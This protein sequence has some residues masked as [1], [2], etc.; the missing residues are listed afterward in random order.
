MFSLTGS[1]EIKKSPSEVYAFLVDLQNIPKWEGEVLEVKVSTPGP[2]RVGTEFTEK[3]K[4]SMKTVEARC[5]MTGLE[6]DRLMSFK[7]D[8][9]MLKYEGSYRL[10]PVTGGTK[11][12]V[13]GQAQFG[14]I[15]R[16]VGGIMKG[17]LQK[18]V[19]VKLGNLK[20]VLEA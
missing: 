14:G 16:L 2:M 19:A 8:S 11:V 12:M 13:D 17:E 6:P 5:V 20:K 15:L 9:K 10:E 7:A 1:I 18:E 4:M 3:I